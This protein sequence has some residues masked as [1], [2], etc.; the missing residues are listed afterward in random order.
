MAMRRSERVRRPCRN[1]NIAL[2]PSFG[3]ALSRRRNRNR[4]SGVT[5]GEAKSSARART[6]VGG[7]GLVHVG[8]QRSAHV[9]VA[10][11]TPHTGAYST[12]ASLCYGCSLC[13]VA[14]TSITGARHVGLL[15]D[16]LDKKLPGR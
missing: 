13:L 1:S 14:S 2:P 16:Q 9:Y 15:N 6:T 3:L 10:P 11:L 12:F 7:N 5:P 8:A 4:P